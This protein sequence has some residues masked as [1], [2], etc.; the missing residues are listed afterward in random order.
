MCSRYGKRKKVALLH[1]DSLY[2]NIF[3][4]PCGRGRSTICGALCVSPLSP[5]TRALKN[6]LRQNEAFAILNEGAEQLLETK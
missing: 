2:F 5:A 3:S 1:R 4:Q 6:S